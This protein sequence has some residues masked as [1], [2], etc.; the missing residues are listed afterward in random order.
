MK[1][2]DRLYNRMALARHR[3]EYETFPTINGRILIAKFADGG[4]IRLGRDVTINSSF[5]SNPVGGHRTCLLIKGPDALIEIGD[6]AGMSNVIIGAYEHVRIG[7]DVNLGG[8]VKI[9][10]NDFH[11]LIWEERKADVNLRSRPVI[12]EDRCFIGA[13]AIVM[14]GVTIG[15]ESVIGAGAVVTRDVPPGEIWAGNPAKFVKKLPTSES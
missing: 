10:D 14:K 1:L 11:S 15:A 8:G 7:A 12:I 9:F 3:V 4:T 6:R 2:F 5:R 13:D